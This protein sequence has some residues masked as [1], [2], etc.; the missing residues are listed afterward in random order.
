[1]AKQGPPQL[2]QFQLIANTLLR[3]VTQGVVSSLFP[4]HSW[5]SNEVERSHISTFQSSDYY[6]EENLTNNNKV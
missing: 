6:T 2:N 5:T 4:C 3:D 1:M